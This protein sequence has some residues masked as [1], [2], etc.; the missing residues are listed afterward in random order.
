MLAQFEKTLNVALVCL[1]PSVRLV[2]ENVNLGDLTN[3]LKDPRSILAT[4]LSGHESHDDF[5]P[6]E[7]KHTK[8]FLIRSHPCKYF[9]GNVRNIVVVAYLRSEGVAEELVQHPIDGL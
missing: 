3:H 5:F 6:N 9:L 1:V 7:V 2:C 8:S 4:L